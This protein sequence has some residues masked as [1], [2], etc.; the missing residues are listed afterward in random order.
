MA[1]L[2]LGIGFIG[3]GSA[4]VV[5]STKK[6]P[7]N[8]VLHFSYGSSLYTEEKRGNL[9]YEKYPPCYNI[10]GATR[11]IQDKLEKALGNNFMNY[12]KL[13]DLYSIVL[14]QEVYIES[15]RRNEMLQQRIQDLAS[16]GGKINKKDIIKATSEDMSKFLTLAKNL[17]ERQIKMMLEDNS[18]NK[19]TKKDI[20][21]LNSIFY[22]IH[23]GKL[24]QY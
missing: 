3:L 16:M 19:D 2:L 5:N 1:F 13:L 21:K 9:M 6:H 7:E 11:S 12:R 15:K 8:K 10:C 23:F 14:C 20:I 24:K 18:I 4:L 22:E 17:I